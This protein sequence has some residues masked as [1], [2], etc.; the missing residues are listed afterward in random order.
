MRIVL[1]AAALSVF[2]I[3]CTTRTLPV[4]GQP[5]MAPDGGMLLDL[6]VGLPDG[7][8]IAPCAAE[9]TL[10]V[11]GDPG[12]VLHPGAET[13]SAA[14]WMTLNGP[15]TDTFGALI[16]AGSTQWEVAFSSL[17]LG[18]PLT[19]GYYGDAVTWP[20]TAHGQATFKIYADRNPPPVCQL[21]TGWF[22][23]SSIAGGPTS[24]EVT[25]ITAAFEQ[26]CD[27]SAAALRGCINLRR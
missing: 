25:Q 12:E 15:D 13:V 18:Q 23:I 19:P 10:Y 21:V 2:A 16:P 7:A 4:T 27:G 26:H 9:N 3:G 17:G 22:Y 14:T 6:A 20:Q 1:A 5:D 24:A 11:E 8:S